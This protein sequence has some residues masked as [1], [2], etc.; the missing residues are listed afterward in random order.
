MRTDAVPTPSDNTPGYD[1][2]AFFSPM[3][4]DIYRAP[5][6]DSATSTIPPSL[7]TPGPPS[8][9]RYGSDA[10]GTGQHQ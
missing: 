6:T 5:S 9:W 1:G 4:T 3:G 10:D 2:G 7:M 8:K